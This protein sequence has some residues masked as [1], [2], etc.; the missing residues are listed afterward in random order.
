MDEKKFIDALNEIKQKIDTLT[1]TLWAEAKA[2][3]TLQ[4]GNEILQAKLKRIEEA[5]K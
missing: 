1:G 3:A 2:N 4:A 5:M